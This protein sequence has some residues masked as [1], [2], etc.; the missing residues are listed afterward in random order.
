MKNHSQ[1]GFSLIE[2]LLVVTIIMVIASISVHWYWKAKLAAENSS[3]VATLNI[4]RQ[5]QASFFVQN[6][7][8]AQ[9]DQLS[10]I[11]GGGLGTVVNS[12]AGCAFLPCI[13]QSAFKFELVTDTG[14]LQNEYT[15]LATRTRDTAP[16]FVYSLNQSGVI[17]RISPTP[18]SVD[19]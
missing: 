9:M 7:R 3:A 2:L 5:N 18:G 14:N 4:M 15:I 12:G 10:T 19:Q 8:F 17:S 13:Q 6:Q 11:Q 16:L 1:Q